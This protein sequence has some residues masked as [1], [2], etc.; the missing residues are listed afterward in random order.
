MDYEIDFMPVGD[1]HGDAICIRY[2]HPL[3]GYVVDVIDGNYS[4]TGDEIIG[5]LRR[6]WGTNVINNLILTHADNDHAVGLIKVMEACHVG[7][8]RMN[9]PWLYVDEV[10]HYYHGNLTRHGFIDKFEDA[11]PYLVEL[12]RLAARD[13]TNV[14]PRHLRLL[15][16]VGAITASL[17]LAHP[18]PRQRPRG[19][20]RP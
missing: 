20:Q 13:G 4:D 3:Y 2:G 10:L 6:Y 12:E 15:H 19:V 1:S 14:V 8:L 9:R 11:H 18:G 16:R 17:H 5:H 7:T